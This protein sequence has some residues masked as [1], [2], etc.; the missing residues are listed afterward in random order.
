MERLNIVKMSMHPKLMYKFNEVIIKISIELFTEL[1]QI[2]MNESRTTWRI[3]IVKFQNI[4]DK[5]QTLKV[6]RKKNR[7]FDKDW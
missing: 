4:K 1:D 3:M 2:E 7:S 6:P 5:E